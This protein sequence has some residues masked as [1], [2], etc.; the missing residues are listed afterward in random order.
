MTSAADV[1]AAIDETLAP[2]R[3]AYQE[4]ILLPWPDPISIE[5]AELIYLFDSYGKQYLDLSSGGLLNPVGHSNP[6]IIST[7]LDHLSHYGPTGSRAHLLRYQAEYAQTLSESLSDPEGE[8][9]RVIY[10]ESEREAVLSAVA[11]AHNVS[12]CDEVAVFGDYT[13]LRLATGKRWHVLRECV[14]DDDWED[15][16]A[17]LIDLAHHQKMLDRQWLRVIV[18]HARSAGVPV[19]V[20]ESRSGFGRLGVAWGHQLYGIEPDMVVIGGPVGGGFPLGVVVASDLEGATIPGSPA[21]GN[22]VACAAGMAVIGQLHQGLLEHVKDAGLAF[23]VAVEELRVQ[24]PG[25][26]AGQTGVGLLRDVEIIDQLGGRSVSQRI[27]EGALSRGLL[28]DHPG[29]INHLDITPPL[30]IS[31]NEMCRAVDILASVLLEWE[32]PT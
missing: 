21:A 5:R 13:W 3:A 6:A 20:D 26:I 19:I 7:V 15:I 16:G 14:P 27:W 17:L 29:F 18:E 8:P 9:R 12:G 2:R 31:E 23:E 4:R 24:F 10:F 22:P 30:I 32:T 1:A 28:L 25:F 11:M